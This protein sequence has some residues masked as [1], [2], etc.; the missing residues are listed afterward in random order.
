MKRVPVYPDE[1]DDSNLPGYAIYDQ[2]VIETFDGRRLEGP[3]VDKVRGGPDLPLSSE[4]LWNKFEDCV[5]HGG[6]NSGSNARELFDHLLSL[7]SIDNIGPL[8][9]QIFGESKVF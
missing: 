7:D 6:M 8:V 4:A 1:R 2:V 9:E 3:R 5:R